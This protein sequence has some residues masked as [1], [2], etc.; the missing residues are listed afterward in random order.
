[1]SSVCYAADSVTAA[2]CKSKDKCKNN[3]NEKRKDI[4]TR[5]SKGKCR[6]NF[7]SEEKESYKGKGKS[8]N[9]CRGK[10]AGKEKESDKDKG[11]S[12][13]QIRRIKG[14]KLNMTQILEVL[15]G[16]VRLAKR[17][18]V[19]RKLNKH[20][21]LL[22]MCEISWERTMFQSRRKDWIISG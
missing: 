1:M 2:L 3:F 20:L 19:V 9:E 15:Q 10:F 16:E 4:N 17:L 7:N 5:R 22:V 13:S 8:E 12:E 14:L 6:S 21:Q 18:L 11:N